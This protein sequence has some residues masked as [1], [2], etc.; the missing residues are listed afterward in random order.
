MEL[1]GKSLY[2]KVFIHVMTVYMLHRLFDKRLRLVTSLF[3]NNALNPFANLLH[4]SRK[5]FQAELLHLLVH[6]FVLR[7]NK[8]RI[9]LIG[10][11]ELM[12]IG[13]KLH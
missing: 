3:L 13:H 4:P 7:K 9:H 12:N 11:K 5:L 10:Q 2:G 8:S 1:H 6:I